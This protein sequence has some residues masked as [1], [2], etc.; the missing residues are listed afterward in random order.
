MGNVSR[1]VPRNVHLRQGSEEVHRPITLSHKRGV[2]RV[3]PDLDA[4]RAE[5][6]ALVASWEDA[7]AMG[8]GRSIQAQRHLTGSV[9]GHTEATRPRRHDPAVAAPEI[10]RRRVDE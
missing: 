9:H 1:R 6:N 2:D 3:M 5:L 10:L 4:L 8:Q 7:F